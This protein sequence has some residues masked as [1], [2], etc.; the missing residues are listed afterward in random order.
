MAPQAI[1]TQLLPHP[2]FE[3]IYPQLDRFICLLITLSVC[4]F[5]VV[6]EWAAGLLEVRPLL[7]FCVSF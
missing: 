5:S 1:R 3:V 6:A 7:H 2:Y 4:L